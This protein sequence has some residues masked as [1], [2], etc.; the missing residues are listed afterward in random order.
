MFI[1]PWPH[2]LDLY[3]LKMYLSTKMKFVGKGIQ[4]LESK[5]DTGRHVLLLLVTLTCPW[6]DDL[7][8]QIWNLKS[9][10]KIKFLGQGFWNTHT[11]THR[12]TDGCD[13]THYH[14]TLNT[15]RLRET[16]T[17]VWKHECKAARNGCLAD[18]ASIRFSTIVHST[19][20]SSIIASFFRTFIAYT[21]SVPFSSASNTFNEYPPYR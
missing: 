17:L 9:T 13:Q 8:M 6:P 15:Y 5:Q 2:D 21:S 4:T 14:T 1:W 16:Q 11:H 18:S 19:S 7:D 3:V 20:S 10:L 12:E